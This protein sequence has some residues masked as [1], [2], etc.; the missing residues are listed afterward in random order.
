MGKMF[1]FIEVKYGLTSNQGC[2]ILPKREKGN[3]TTTNLT[4]RP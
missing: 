1:I 2:Q 4:K 3:Q